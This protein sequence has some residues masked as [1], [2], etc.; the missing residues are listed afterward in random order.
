[1][2]KTPKIEFIEF[3]PELTSGQEEHYNS[4]V[5]FDLYVK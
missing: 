3:K 5:R 1:M 2:L 4:C